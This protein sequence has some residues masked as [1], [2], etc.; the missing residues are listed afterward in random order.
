MTTALWPPTSP[1]PEDLLHEGP[2]AL[3]G[4]ALLKQIGIRALA[5]GM[6]LTGAWMM[7]RTR[8]N[9]G[10]ARTVSLAALVGTQL[11]L[12][13]VLRETAP[14]VLVSTL[15]LRA[16]LR[17]G[18]QTSSVSQF[19]WRTTLGPVEYRSEDSDNTCQVRAIVGMKRGG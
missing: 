11:G 18:I 16:V 12:A 13:V 3:L 1:S 15:V 9:R 10:R 2:E 14:M 6:G 17:C 5:T 8:R 4:A 7:A 19:V